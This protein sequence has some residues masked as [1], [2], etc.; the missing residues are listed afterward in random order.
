[1]PTLEPSPEGVTT[2]PIITKTAESGGVVLTC[3]CGWLRWFTS[4]APSSGH[5]DAHAKKCSGA[6]EPKTNAAPKRAASKWNEREGATWI[7]KL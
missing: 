1:M 3:E 5:G 7:D 2:P 6:R 4:D